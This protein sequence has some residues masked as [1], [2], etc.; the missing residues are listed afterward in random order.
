MLEA[1]SCRD[2][3]RV[4]SCQAAGQAWVSACDQ[5]AIQV[6]SR[7]IPEEVN[8]LLNPNHPGYS[9]LVWSEPREFR[10]DPRLFVTEPEIL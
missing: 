4:A 9:E 7:V 1:L 5:L 10:F 8:I 3:T 2:I 6:P